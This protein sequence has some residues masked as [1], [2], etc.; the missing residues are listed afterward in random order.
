M[1]NDVNEIMAVD[2]M[3]L[4]TRSW[5]LQLMGGD[6]GDGA[7]STV[8]HLD[9]QLGQGSDF[10]QFAKYRKLLFHASCY[11]YATHDR[12]QLILDTG[13]PFLSL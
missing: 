10:Y 3:L 11:F 6:G 8:C 9:R 4:V 12:T 13:L 5:E 2:R 1:S 7:V